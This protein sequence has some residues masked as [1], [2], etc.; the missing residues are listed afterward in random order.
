MAVDEQD[1][2]PEATQREAELQRQ[3]DEP[4]GEAQRTLQATGTERREAQPARIIE[5]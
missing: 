4:E 3:I 2:Q 5:S 1:E